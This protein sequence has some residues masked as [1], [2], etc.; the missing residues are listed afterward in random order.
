MRSQVRFLLAP[1]VV[2]R[3][4]QHWLQTHGGQGPSKVHVCPGLGG[5]ECAGANGVS[6]LDSK[7]GIRKLWIQPHLESEALNAI[8]SAVI[9]VLSMLITHMDYE[10]DSTVLTLWKTV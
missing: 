1:L 10:F 8:T 2:T 5:G 7:S 6:E 3:V 4:S 9:E